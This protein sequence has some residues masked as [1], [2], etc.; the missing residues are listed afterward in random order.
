MTLSSD[1]RRPRVN[2]EHFVDMKA[3][4]DI[5][6]A[7]MHSATYRKPS[8]VL[9]DVINI[10]DAYGEATQHRSHEEPASTPV[11]PASVKIPLDPELEAFIEFSL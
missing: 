11:D 1:A 7:V 5:R 2:A 8:Q 3:L 9:L 4:N 10:L 6:R